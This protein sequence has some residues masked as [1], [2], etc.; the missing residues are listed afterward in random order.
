[1]FWAQVTRRM[2][3]AFTEVGKACIIRL[4]GGVPLTSDGCP[5]CPLGTASQVLGLM[6]LDPAERSVLDRTTP[7]VMKWNDITEGD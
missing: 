6:G 3:V 1:M 5:V 4:W 2:A 7:E